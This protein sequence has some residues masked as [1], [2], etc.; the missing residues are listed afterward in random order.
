MQQQL[1]LQ[2]C[3]R[4]LS[5]AVPQQQEPDSLAAVSEPISNV[6]PARSS[7]SCVA[8]PLPDLGILMGSCLVPAIASNLNRR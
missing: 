4:L 1:H 5:G 3:S 8:E 7:T 6:G 2:T